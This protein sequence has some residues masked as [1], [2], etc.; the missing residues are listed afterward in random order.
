MLFQ[1]QSFNPVVNIAIA[2]LQKLKVEVTDATVN[3]TLEDHPDF[4]SLLS[5][6]DSLKKWHID[7]AAMEVEPEK[8]DELPAP[9]IAVL[10]N[11]SFVLVT[12]NAEQITYISDKNNSVIRSKEH[13]LKEWKGI[14][15]LAEAN[16]QSGDKNYTKAKRKEQIQ[17]LKIPLI[18]LS[19]LSIS[20][21]AMY[22]ANWDIAFSIYVSLH[23]LGVIVSS[24]LLWY[25]IDKTNPLLKQICSASKK[26]NCNAILN[27]KQSKLFNTISWSE[28]GFFY[29]AGNFIFLLLSSVISNQSSLFFIA[30]LNL[31][32]LP[33]TV[34][35]VYYQ[36]RVA[37]QWCTLCLAVQFLLLSTFVT[38]ISFSLLPS[39]FSFIPYATIASSYIL[40]IIAWVLLKPILLKAQQLKRSKREL[41]RLKYDARIFDALLP[42]QKRITASAEG[43]GIT[44]GNPAAINTIIKVCNPY[45]GPCAKAHPEIEALIKNNKDIKA[46]ILFT[47]T[48]DEKDIKSLPVKHLLA[49]D[50]KGDKEVTV[51]ALDDWY[52]AE[53]RDYTA[54]DYTEFA[55]KY[56]MNRELKEQDEKIKQMEEWCK[57]IEITFTPTYFVNG[58]QLPNVYEISDIQYFLAE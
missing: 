1:F 6:S 26:T 16:A 7:T 47:A 38:S 41:A 30:W 35:S 46:M 50:A 10:N 21:A 32:A 45:C 34:F 20:V 55:N 36:W 5:I 48:N 3:E 49:I 39:N 44:I 11:N 54:R 51:K 37:K 15:L 40:P 14:A 58:Y 13:F 56:P 25:E 22:K 2:L 23:L 4:P 29:F 24:L 33:Y 28:I 52:L 19:I 27:S 31:L 53:K 42:K 17:G 43:L 8:L 18:L 57:K 9:F 12:N